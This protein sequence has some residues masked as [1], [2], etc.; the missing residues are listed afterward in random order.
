M[1]SMP[2][3]GQ[4]ADDSHLPPWQLADAIDDPQSLD[5]DA[6]DH[7]K[8]CRACET[9]LLHA[10]R[11]ADD[12]GLN[13]SVPTATQL[14]DA[15]KLSTLL[16]SNMAAHQA[17]PFAQGQVWQLSGPDS[18][19]LAVITKVDQ[20]GA[21]VVP[22]TNDPHELTDPYT[23]QATL[24]RS[25]L[26]VAVWFSLETFIH[27]E[28]FAW[29]IDEIDAGLVVAGRKAWRTGLPV[30]GPYVAGQ[31]IV[32]N[33]QVVTYREQ[34]QQRI[35]ALGEVRLLPAQNDDE[36][37]TPGYLTLKGLGV[38]TRSIREILGIN[39]TEAGDLLTGDRSISNDEAR[40]LSEALDAEVSP[41]TII[42][43]PDLL[44]VVVAPKVRVLFIELASRKQTDEW[45]ERRT[46]VEKRLARAAR[47]SDAISKW[48]EML[49]Q[50]LLD[51]LDAA[52]AAQLQDE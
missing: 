45:I 4:W 18:S 26:V 3:T 47:S 44:A 12:C 14:P 28:V 30:D 27:T 11:S 37:V 34:L 35:T 40:V 33:A 2:N 22:L 50:Y 31:S 51:E 21:Y 43:D 52:K 5:R 48:E 17:L 41:T 9:Q 13:D 25:S 36:E 15:A 46:A 7:L 24:S 29:T 16:V 6:A 39:A 8:T 32:H 42:P 38:K 10:Q 49:N 23:L 20:G 19:D 1:G